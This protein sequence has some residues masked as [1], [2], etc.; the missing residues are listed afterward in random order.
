[1]SEWI[2]R[3]FNSSCERMA[4]IPDKSV[5]CCVTSPPYWGKRSYTADDGMIGMEPTLQEYIDRLVAVFREVRR[6][7]R[8]DGTLWLNL[9]DVYASG[10]SCSRVSTIGAR[11]PHK[12]ERVNRLSEGI[13]NKD[14]I[15]LPWTVAFA[16]RA[17]GWFLRSEIIWTKPAPMPESVTD[18]PTS[19]H[20]QIFLLS[21]RA[22]YYYDQ[23]TIREPLSE[24]SIVRLSQNVEEQEGSPVPGKTN[25]AMK[26]V[27]RK[28]T[29]DANDGSRAGRMRPS[30]GNWEQRKSVGAPSRHGTDGCRESDV[31]GKNF[32]GANA[33]DVWTI[34]SEGYPGEHFA[35]FPRD[36]VR[37][38]ILAGSPG[39]G[40]VLDPFMGS[41]TTA[42]VAIG[43]GRRYIG[44]EISEQYCNLIRER[45]G[46]FGEGVA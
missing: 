27:A 30:A 6:V 7:L 42:E 46:L 17:D 15:G 34:A 44:Y 12:N 11:S 22:R 43:C 25:G 23:D 13:K 33:R 40:I 38:C 28:A 35:T 2:N 39:G 1:M 14:L 20:E 3:V 41:G 24:S 21:K 37:R 9:G 16:L 36:L 45:L 26:A 31:G 29:A 19:S 10:W 32:L 8:D 4:E 5:H 18:R